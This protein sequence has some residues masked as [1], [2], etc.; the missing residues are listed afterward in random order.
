MD[1]K[2]E[3]FNKKKGTNVQK[4]ISNYVIVIENTVG[5]QS[6]LGKTHTPSVFLLTVG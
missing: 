1:E 3:T 4:M 6:E 5:K 2:T